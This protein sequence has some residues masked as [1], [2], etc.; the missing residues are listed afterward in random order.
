MFAVTEHEL[1][2]VFEVALIFTLN[3]HQSFMIHSPIKL[4]IF[5][6]N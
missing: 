5:L 4:I 6:N 1:Y 2:Y 3:Y